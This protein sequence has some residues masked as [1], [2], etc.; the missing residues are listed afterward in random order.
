M[1]PEAML[2]VLTMIGSLVAQKCAEAVLV[3]TWMKSKE[4]IFALFGRRDHG[5][6]AIPA[7][8]SV[9]V[10]EDLQRAAE[11]IL[12]RT[13]SLRRAQLVRQVLVG[14]RVLWIDDCPENNVWERGMFRALGAETVC[15]RQT[16]TALEL[17][18]SDSFDCVISDIHRQGVSDAGLKG[19]QQIRQRT[20]LP[21]IFYVGR[22]DPAAGIPP[23]SSGITN[24]PDELLH[25]LLDVLERSR[26]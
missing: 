19:L 13:S 3:N 2:P 6:V 23:Y 1:N 21:V 24:R 7:A 10:P 11:L 12:S 15:V 26:V 20:E 18:T 17:L 25:L 22:V 4:F 5:E 9:E 14:A 8:P 16:E